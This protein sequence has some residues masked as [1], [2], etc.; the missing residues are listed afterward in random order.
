VV[1]AAIR[2]FSD[3]GWAGTG[4]R[5]VAR[6][7]GV[8]VETVYSNFGSKADLLLAA[9]DV[10]VVGDSQPIPLG[11]RPEFAALGRGPLSARTAAAARL[12]RQIH[13]R[14]SGIGRA[15]REAAAGDVEL[16]KRLADGEE[17]RRLNV[18]QGAQL[19]AGRP[20]TDTVRDGLWAV[21]GMEV[22]ELLVVR[23]G[24]SAARYEEWLADTIGRLMRPGGKERR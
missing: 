13:E 16:A 15:L 5:D 1:D 19:I 3:N 4:M 14:T 20:I 21:L 17:R 12:V 9:L 23:A 24:W 8:A 11:E 10:A 22:Y 6:V 2:L 7:A 18:E